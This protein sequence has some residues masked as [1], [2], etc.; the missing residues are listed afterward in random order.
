MIYEKLTEQDRLWTDTVM[1]K[2][3]EK[4]A[5]VRERSANKIPSEA[6]DGVHDD[7][8]SCE[9]ASGMTRTFWTNG[10]WAGM[11]WLLYQE[12]N[13]ERYTEIARYTETVLGKYLLEIESHDIGYLWLPSF[14]LDYRL[15]GSK[16]AMESGLTAAKWLAGRYN[17]AGGF[18]RAWGSGDEALPLV[19]DAPPIHIA[20]ATIIDCMLNLPLLYWAS[21]VSKDPRFRLIAMRHA[22]TTMNHFVRPNGSVIHIVEFNPESGVYV[23]D[24][25]GQGYGKGS[26]WTRGQAW[27]LYGF[28]ASYRHTGEKRYLET[29]KKIAAN[30]MANIPEN[31]LIPSDF[32]QPAEPHVQDDI[33]ACAAACGLIELAGQVPGDQKIPYLNAAVKMLR[34]IDAQSADWSADTDGITQNGTTGYHLP[35]RNKNYVYA[36]YFYI[37]AVMKLQDKGVFVNLPALLLWNITSESDPEFYLMIRF[38]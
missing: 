19:K 13:D 21:E 1:N 20:G 30:F 17:P 38:P 23:S 31:G 11:M 18:I 34:A 29:A 33:G 15:T 26:S 10:F 8:A 27:G 36:D 16:E 14:V 32:D 3:T 25:G 24:H 4:L 12:T 35:G 7:K 28:T 37:E 22:D 2:I 6:I 9:G 5:A